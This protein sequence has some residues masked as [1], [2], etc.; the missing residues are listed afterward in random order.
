MEDLKE[1][2]KRLSKDVGCFYHWNNIAQNYS[3][4]GYNIPKGKLRQER[5]K[6]IFGWVIKD[7][8]IGGFEIHL[9]KLDSGRW[10]EANCNRRIAGGSWNEVD[11]F[12]FS[13]V[14]GSNSNDY[15]KALKACRIVMRKLPQ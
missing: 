10:L 8:A 13:V 3:L 15:E 7:K 2:V 9:Q 4:K 12:C 1:F 5:K 14:R 6:N 11:E